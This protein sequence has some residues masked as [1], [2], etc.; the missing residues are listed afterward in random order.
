MDNSQL[1]YIESLFQKNK[2]Y[3]RSK[4]LDK[5][6]KM[7][8]ELKSLLE[9]GI[10]EKIKTGLYK[11]NRF[12][13]HN[14]WVD[15]CKIYPQGV[16]CLY[17]AWHYF[18]L[19]THIP[20]EYHIAIPNKLKLKEYEYPPIKFHYWNNKNYEMEIVKIDEMHIYS[21]E[22]SVCDAIKFKTKI[23]IDT[24]KEVI[25]NYLKRKD[26][27]LDKLFEIS[28]E[29]KIEKITREYIDTFI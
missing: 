3:L 28:K 14:E 21:L 22:K 13:I 4:D 9:N 29:M 25:N 20:F 23:G 24:L 19:T 16:L 5:N 27:N 7:Y 1:Q 12:V 2:G 10:V 15:V 11:H 18:E 8:Y 6:R 26:R 17:S